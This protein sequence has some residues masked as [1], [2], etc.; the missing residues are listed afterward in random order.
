[1]KDKYGG[2]WL[3]QN[4]PFVD[5]SYFCDTLF[6]RKLN[7]QKKRIDVMRNKYL[8]AISRKNQIKIGPTN[9]ACAIVG[10]SDVFTGGIDSF[11]LNVKT[12]ST[13]KTPV[14]VFEFVKDGIFTE[15]FS[16]FGKNLNRLC[17]TQ[18]QIIRFVKDHAKWLRADGFGTFFLFKEKGKFFVARVLQIESGPR[19]NK[20]HMSCDYDVYAVNR[21]RFVIPQ[22]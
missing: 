8:R 17:F 4:P 5:I 14:R 6:I 2:F 21:H 13:K 19:V 11:R 12:R 20:I 18:D 15:I 1:M 7:A 22:L 3:R 16:G 10:A 9:G